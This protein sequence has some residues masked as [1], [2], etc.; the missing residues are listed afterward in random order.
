MG[1]ILYEVDVKFD[2]A[3]YF[4]ANSTLCAAIVALFK[5]RYERFCYK[6]N[7]KLYFDI[8]DGNLFAVEK[9]K[10]K[11]KCYMVRLKVSNFGLGF[12]ENVKLRIE[13]THKNYFPP[14][15]LTWTNCFQQGQKDKF[16]MEKMY[17]NLDYYCDFAEIEGFK[18]HALVLS[19]EVTP[20]S[21]KTK[22]Q[23]TFVSKKNEPEY[24]ILTLFA[25][26]MMPKQYYMIFHYKKWYDVNFLDQM[27]HDG[28]FISLT[29]RKKVANR[30][31]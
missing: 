4:V 12:A 2:Y 26:N 23:N 21:G 20:C 6:P 19:T 7:L 18:N 27:K 24:F 28:I 31:I 30:K 13:S 16:N 11:I 5:D 29:E 9:S 1:I 17:L 22:F 15:Y 25:D 3:Q 10:N 14:M 8:E